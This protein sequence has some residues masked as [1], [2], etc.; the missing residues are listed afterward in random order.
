MFRLWKNQ[1]Y[2]DADFEK[3]KQQKQ[4]TFSA[5]DNNSIHKFAS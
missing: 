3:K 2:Y 1:V 4:K 5:Q